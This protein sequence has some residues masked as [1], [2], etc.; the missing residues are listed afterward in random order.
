M[1]SGIPALGQVRKHQAESPYEDPE[2]TEQGKQP[3]QSHRC[4]GCTDEFTFG[5]AK[6]SRYR[7]LA[8]NRG[9]T[10]VPNSI[11]ALGFD[12]TLLAQSLH[13]FAHG[14]AAHAKTLG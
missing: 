7:R 9:G 12:Q 2:Q 14:G 5:S 3:G 8:H 10:I 6:P 11:S 4:V 1:L 13:R